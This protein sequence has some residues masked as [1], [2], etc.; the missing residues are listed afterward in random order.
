MEADARRIK[1]EDDGHNVRTTSEKPSYRSW[2]K[3]Y[4]KMRIVFDDKMKANEDLH[5]M[6]QKALATAKRLAIQNE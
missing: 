1:D 4:R 6:E 5:M 2:K 3:K